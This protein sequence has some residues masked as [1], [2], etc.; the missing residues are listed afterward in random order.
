MPSSPEGK[1]CPRPPPSQSSQLSS[2]LRRRK[3]EPRVGWRRQAAA[4][5]CPG[6]SRYSS[7][8]SLDNAPLPDLPSSADPRSDKSQRPRSVCSEAGTSPDRRRHAECVPLPPVASSLVGLDTI[9][10]LGG[11]DSTAVEVPDAPVE[12]LA[13]LQVQAATTSVRCL[14]VPLDLGWF[15]SPLFLGMVVCDPARSSKS[16][17][18]AGSP[19]PSP[20]MN[21]H[22][23]L[24]GVEQNRSAPKESATWRGAFQRG[25]GWCADLLA[26]AEPD[27]E[28]CEDAASLVRQGLLQLGLAASGR[29]LRCKMQSACAP[30]LG[31]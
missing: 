19:L 2:S 30:S 29:K 24:S 9:G 10:P 6:I 1:I 17:S 31:S 23:R 3:Y 12:T 18:K 22:R 26:A 27:E 8:M 20:A 5:E 28:G 14:V 15:Q 13:E 4:G 21:S 11:V 25:C 7:M 16:T